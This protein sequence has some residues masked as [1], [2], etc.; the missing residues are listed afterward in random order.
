MYLKL[1]A[2]NAKITYVG[3]RTNLPL[4]NRNYSAGAKFIL[5]IFNIK[6]NVKV[7]VRNEKDIL[8]FIFDI[9]D[10]FKPPKN[11]NWILSKIIES[12]Q[13]Q[14][15]LL[16]RKIYDQSVCGQF[17][18]YDD[19]V[20]DYINIAKRHYDCSDVVIHETIHWLLNNKILSTFELMWLPRTTEITFV[21]MN[22]LRA[23]RDLNEFRCN[24]DVWEQEFFDQGYDY[25]CMFKNNRDIPSHYVDKIVEFNLIQAKSNNEKILQSNGAFIAGIIKGILGDRPSLEAVKLFLHKLMAQTPLEEALRDCISMA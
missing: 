5:N 10:K 8:D 13:F 16:Y 3:F 23:G 12:Y 11:K 1:T 21:L 19:K 22:L 18:A 24:H 17:F 4:L 15:Y 2:D 14:H 7:S 20:Y 25:Y 6:N 9:I